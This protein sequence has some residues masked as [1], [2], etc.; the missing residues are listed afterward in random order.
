MTEFR[1]LRE[2][3]DIAVALQRGIVV[4][5]LV[6]G[7]RPCGGLERDG[8]RRHSGPRGWSEVPA[9][10]ASSR[11]FGRAS[12]HARGPSRPA[13]GRLAEEE[14]RPPVVRSLVAR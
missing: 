3:R 12:R 11:A 1:R 4:P 9:G 2:V 10:S 8:S 6:G 14:A 13:R 5:N 7:D